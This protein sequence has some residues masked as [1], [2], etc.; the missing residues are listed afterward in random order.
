MAVVVMAD[1]LIV[2]ATITIAVSWHWFEPKKSDH[3]GKVIAYALCDLNLH[4]YL[5]C[6]LI[7]QANQTS[8]CKA[9]KKRKM[10]TC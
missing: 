1:F 10:K 7:Y 8:L 6:T 3:P 5:N 4:S 2:Q 9:A